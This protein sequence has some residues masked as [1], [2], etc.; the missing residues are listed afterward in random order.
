MFKLHVGPGVKGLWVGHNSL[1]G[2]GA[3]SINSG[4]DEMVLPPGTRLLV[5]N[6]RK[7]G[8]DA[9]GFGAHGQQHVI[10][11]IILPTE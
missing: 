9:D 6:V 2:G 5:L 10:E 1:P 4:E 11:A 8:K 3:L 7:G